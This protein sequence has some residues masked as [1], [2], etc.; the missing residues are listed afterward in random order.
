MHQ[1]ELLTFSKSPFSIKRK[2]FRQVDSKKGQLQ[3]DDYALFVAC[4]L[5]KLGY[6][7]GDPNY[8]L[9]SRVDHVLAVLC[10]EDVENELYYITM[11]EMRNANK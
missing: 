3:I 4:K 1:G 5:S 6:F 8:V 9:N 2:H 7:N 11:E 10:Y